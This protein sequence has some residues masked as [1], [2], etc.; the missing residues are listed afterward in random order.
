VTRIVRSSARA[1][2][3][4]DGVQQILW[5][6]LNNA[7]KFTP[8]DGRIRVRISRGNR[9]ACVAIEDSGVGIE[10]DFLPFMFDRFCQA[11]PG[12]TR[13]FGG[14]GLGLTTVKELMQL[15]GGTVKATTTGKD[16]G[17]AVTLEFPV[18]EVLDQPG[19]WLR[20]RAGIEP[21]HARLDGISILIVD[22][23]PEVLATLEGI[24]RHHGAEVL[25]AASAE[26]ALNLLDQH[27]PTV[28]ATG[29][30]SSPSCRSPAIHRNCSRH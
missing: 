23:E 5:N 21:P 22:D 12:S 30:C 17:T 6:V 4:A 15:H 9:Q 14:M 10:P 16:Q 19:T 18:P 29:D 20:R 13:R 2:T 1:L 8:N 24:L 11:D 25:T 28:L 26:E 27:R 7:I 3:Q